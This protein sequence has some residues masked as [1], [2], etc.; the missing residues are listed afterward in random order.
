MRKA[1]ASRNAQSL[2]K[3]GTGHLEIWT[4]AWFGIFYTGAWGLVSGWGGEKGACLSSC[5][6]SLLNCVGPVN[7]THM[8]GDRA[9][10]SAWLRQ[11]TSPSLSLLRSWYKRWAP[12]LLWTYQ[13]YKAPHT[14]AGSPGHPEGPPLCPLHEDSRPSLKPSTATILNLTHCRNHRLISS[15]RPVETV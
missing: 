4:S 9:I 1:E 2:A 13:M 10:E 6:L 3:I 7:L 5:S 12:L 14:V 8:F 15:S 11:H